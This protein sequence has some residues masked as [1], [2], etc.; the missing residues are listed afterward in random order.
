MHVLVVRQTVTCC[1]TSTKATEFHIRITGHIQSCFGGYLYRQLNFQS[2]AHE[3]SSMA[4]TTSSSA[5]HHQHLHS[6]IDPVL[7]TLNLIIHPQSELPPVQ[8]DSS[9][10]SLPPFLHKCFPRPWHE[11]LYFS[12]VLDYLQAH[13]TLL[14]PMPKHQRPP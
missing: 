12:M 10:C 2:P 7:R 6:Q 14:I 4:T 13:R 9:V 5:N 3:S 1:R 11:N 8:K